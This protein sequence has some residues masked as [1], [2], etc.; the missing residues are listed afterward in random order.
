MSKLP[1]LKPNVI[2]KALLRNGFYIHHFAGSHAQL[3]HS[4]KLHLRV[5]VP[6][7]TRFDLPSSVL[8]SILNQAELTREEFLGLL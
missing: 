3:R 7:H 8:Q 4:Q 1:A 6:R 5:T 2:L